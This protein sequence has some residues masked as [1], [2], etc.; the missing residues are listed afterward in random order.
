MVTLRQ[1]QNGIVK[2]ID[3]EMLPKMDGWK[4]WVFG[5]AA[6]LAVTRAESMYE[7]LRHNPLVAALGV[8]DGNGHIDID[9]LYAEFAKQAQRG[10]ISIDMGPLGIYSMDRRD[11]DMIAQFIREG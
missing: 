4:K 11:V 7:A 6:G 9:A 1:V 5:A 3:T 10:P 2:Y 8:I